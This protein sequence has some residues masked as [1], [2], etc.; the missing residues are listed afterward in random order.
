MIKTVMC[1][2]TTDGKLWR[3]IGQAE[4]WQLMLDKMLSKPV[5]PAVHES[6]PEYNMRNEGYENHYHPVGRD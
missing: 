4:L 6:V 1:H 3:S 2:E 5:E